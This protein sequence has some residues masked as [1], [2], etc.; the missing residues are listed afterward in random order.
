MPLDSQTQAYLA[1][2]REL[3]MLPL[4]A[5]PPGVLRQGLALLSANEPVGEPVARVENRTIPGPA[6]EIPVR[7]YTP[8]GNGPFPI[9]VY[10]HGESSIQ[11]SH[12]SWPGI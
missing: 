5:F 12:R 10:L 3:G 8:E 11:W 4:S 1:L 7:I 9:L 6:G 2:M